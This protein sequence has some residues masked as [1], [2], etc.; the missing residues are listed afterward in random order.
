MSNGKL[1]GKI[2]RYG[3]T[4]PTHLGDRFEIEEE[5]NICYIDIYSTKLTTIYIERPT[6]V[7][8]TVLLQELLS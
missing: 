7:H 3:H 5:R 1:G 4:S 8:E 2:S 6:Y